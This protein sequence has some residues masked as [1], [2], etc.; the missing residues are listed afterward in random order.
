MPGEG[1]DQHKPQRVDVG[2]RGGDTTGDLFGAEVGRRADEGS[3]G[4]EPRAVNE[5]RDAEVSEFGPERWAGSGDGP[6]Q[7]VGRF[8]IAVHNLR[9]VHRVQGIGQVEGHGREILARNG[10][11]RNALGESGS[12]DVFH[13]EVGVVA[14]PDSGIKEG[15]QSMVIERR[16]HL[17]L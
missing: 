9:L 10:R 8:E 17:D 16:Q 11:L 12:L 7:N 1:L 6:Q 4:S 5:I 2:G 13:H 14:G 3:R 15:H